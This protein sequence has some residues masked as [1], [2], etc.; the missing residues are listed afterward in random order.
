MKDI[1]YSRIKDGLYAIEEDGRVF[2][3]STGR[4]MK[5]S[6][7]K[8]GYST[9]SLKNADDGYSKFGIH[10]LLMI[11]F[12][13]IEDMEHMTVNHIDGNKVNNSL[14]NLEWVTASENTYLAHKTGL[15]KSI[16]ET[17]GR[18]K[19]TEK[20]AVQILQ[21]KAMGKKNREIVEAMDNKAITL[22]MVQKVVSGETWK[23]LNR[24][25]IMSSTTMT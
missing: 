15:N 14:S 7:D 24:D 20:E 4:Y 2:S 18:A 22:R 17:H 11:A 13:P 12:N 19:M 23:H 10:R 8:D 1:Q 21:M 3:K 6:L 25:K 5:T 9:V 16:G